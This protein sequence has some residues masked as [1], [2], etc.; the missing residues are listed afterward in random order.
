MENGI[1]SRE[2]RRFRCQSENYVNQMTCAMASKL[3]KNVSFDAMFF[4]HVHHGRKKRFPVHMA[5]HRNRQKRRFSMPFSF[6]NV[7]A[8]CRCSVCL[9]SGMR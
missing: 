8:H 4:P 6:L 7:L 5:W 2:K 1:E 9:T 3:R